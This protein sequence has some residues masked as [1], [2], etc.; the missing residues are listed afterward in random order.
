M[1]GCSKCQRTDSP[2][3]FGQGA[4]AH[5]K[6]ANKFWAQYLDSVRES[7]TQ[8]PC[9]SVAVSTDYLGTAIWVHGQC[10][11]CVA[12]VRFGGAGPTEI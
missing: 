3:H 1:T 7:I 4:T 12:N 8:R 6:Y 2:L 11:T 5:P 10:S 9:G